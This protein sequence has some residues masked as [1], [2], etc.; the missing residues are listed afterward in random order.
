MDLLKKPVDCF[1]K[2]DDAQ[3][4]EELTGV[5]DSDEHEETISAKKKKKTTLSKLASCFPEKVLRVVDDGVFVS[6]YQRMLDAKKFPPKMDV[7]KSGTDA[8]KDVS[9]SDSQ[10][11]DE[12]VEKL[13]AEKAASKV[14]PDEV[15]E[16]LGPI[17]KLKAESSERQSGLK[18]DPIGPIPVHDYKSKV[19]TLFKSDEKGRNQE[20]KKS[21]FDPHGEYMKDARR[22]KSRGGGRSRSRR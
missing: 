13:F 21:F 6:P 4:G 7:S 11:N 19:E 22:G 14:T 9:K 5:L 10:S 8:E 16:F 20:G 12:E 3:E 17:K 15:E 1:S 2:H 18:S